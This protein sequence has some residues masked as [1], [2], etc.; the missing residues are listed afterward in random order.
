MLGTWCRKGGQQMN[1]ELVRAAACGGSQGQ[2]SRAPLA[3]ACGGC[4]RFTAC[5]HLLKATI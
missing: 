1:Q 4:R 5:R 2:Q 3:E